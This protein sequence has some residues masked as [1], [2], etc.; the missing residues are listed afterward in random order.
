MKRTIKEQLRILVKEHESALLPTP[1]YRRLRRALL[2][3]AVTGEW[4]APDE[5]AR[6]RPREPQVKSAS[7]VEE[8]P[9][10]T[11]PKRAAKP[12]PAKTRPDPDD[13]LA[14]F[15]DK[16]GTPPPSRQGKAGLFIGALL[17]ALLAVGVFWLVTSG[18]GPT[19]SVSVDATPVPADSAQAQGVIEQFASDEDWTPGSIRRF[20]RDWAD[21]SEQER[22]EAKN[23]GWYREFARVLRDRLKFSELSDANRPSATTDALKQLAVSLDLRVESRFASVQNTR[24]EQMQTQSNQ[25]KI[26]AP[27]MPGEVA[28][29]QARQ[30]STKVVV[31]TQIKTS[32]ENQSANSATMDT[33]QPVDSA[34]PAQASQPATTEEADSDPS[35]T[36]RPDSTVVAGK[37]ASD[38]AG[39][40]AIEAVP[41]VADSDESNSTADPGS[42]TAGLLTAKDGAMATSVSTTGKLAPGENANQQATVD[43]QASDAAV[44]VIPGTRTARCHA[45]LLSK[46][47]KFCRD[48]F[49]DGSQGPKLAVVRAGTF[50]MGS[51]KRAEEKPVH[52]VTISKGFAL[53][54]FEVS[55]SQFGKFCSA[56]DSACPDNPWGDDQLPVVNVS[57]EEAS[58]YTQWLSQQTGATY[59]LPSEAEWEYAARAG[60]QTDY[61]FGDEISFLQAR[62]SDSKRRAQPVIVDGALI[63]SNKLGLKHVVGNASE[64]VADAWRENYTDTV[65]GQAP[66]DGTAS[67]KRVVRGGSYQDRASDLRSS[68]RASEASSGRFVY[69]GF[70]VAR[71]F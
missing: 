8:A 37:I 35:D 15:E 61:P 64:W 62:F 27:L 66:Y 25:E 40:K 71:E 41:V 68:A 58:A 11:A 24:K 39:T 31:A 32:D 9:S 16:S 47:R 36:T 6:T 28:S 23:T 2:E 13:P 26:S 50:K 59:R 60:S 29:E 1:D 5:P 42:S 49:N 52:D 43:P 57:W 56:T 3:R 38:S 33:S 67:S 70:R 21:L 55:F 69:V 65:G 48:T 12:S 19:E 44:T 4:D 51:S 46:R 30:P 10:T 17:L 63:I 53:G 20:A 14:A 54:A 7:V 45:V 18:E 22:L 34:S